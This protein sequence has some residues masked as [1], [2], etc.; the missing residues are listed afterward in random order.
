MAEDLA[1]NAGELDAHLKKAL[2]FKIL[3]Q[4]DK[5][6][7]RHV[8]R[9]GSDGKTKLFYILPHNSKYAVEIVNPYFDAK[10]GVM[11]KIDGVQ[12][13]NW[14]LPKHWIGTIERPVDTAKLFTFL[15][16]KL[17]ADAEKACELLKIN[18]GDKSK[19]SSEERTA[20]EVTPLGSGI[21]P[22][23]DANGLVSVTYIPPINASVIR[24][25]NEFGWFNEH[26]G[27]LRSDTVK[28]VKEKFLVTYPFFTELQF[29]FT[30]DYWRVVKDTDVLGDIFQSRILSSFRVRFVK[31]DSNEKRELTTYFVTLHKE[32]LGKE[33]VVMVEADRLIIVSDFLKQLGEE[34]GFDTSNIVLKCNG[35]VANEFRHILDYFDG[36]SDVVLATAIKN[37]HG[38]GQIFVK[39]LTGKTLTLAL[40]MK[41]TTIYEVKQEL[42]DMTGTSVNEQRLIFAGKQLEDG[43]TLGDYNVQRESTLHMVLRMCGGGCVEPDVRLASGATTLQGEYI[44]IYSFVVFLNVCMCC[45]PQDIQVNSLVLPSICIWIILAPSPLLFV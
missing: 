6:E 32:L 16:T 14:Q 33:M 3:N 43:R 1:R 21:N 20:L 5:T 40:E 37:G 42:E 27:V 7:F 19:L 29:N 26:F 18:G 9:I 10:C 4:V 30:L 31:G 15:R 22:F 8:A 38:T 36:K 12:V 2:G 39:T 41:T 17:V 35:K 11:I 28:S 25:R 34:H 24:V 23:K 45:C 13:G 44:L